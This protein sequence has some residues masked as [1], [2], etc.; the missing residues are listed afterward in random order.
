VEWLK[1]FI[2][3]GRPNSEEKSL[4]ILDLHSAHTKNL[5]AAEFPGDKGPRAHTTLRFQP[6]DVS[7]FEPLSVL[8]ADM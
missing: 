1:H 7:S 6:S 4:L 2:S 8:E 3:S 5:E